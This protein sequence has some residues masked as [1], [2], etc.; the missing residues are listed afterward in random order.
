M[1]VDFTVAPKGGVGIALVNFHDRHYRPEWFPDS[2]NPTDVTSRT[3]DVIALPQS[4]PPT[5]RQRAVP[6]LALQ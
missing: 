6:A 1:R 4:P 2:L 3:G 5:G